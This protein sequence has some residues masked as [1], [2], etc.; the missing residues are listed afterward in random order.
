MALA[1]LILGR[2][3]GGSM[4][5]QATYDTVTMEVQSVSV[6][7]PTRARPTVTLHDTVTGAVLYS[8]RLATGDSDSYD[9]PLAARTVCRMVADGGSVR[10]TLAIGVAQ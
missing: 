8:A 1:T 4:V 6:T 5:A 10:P 3:D 7:K 9:L 2:F